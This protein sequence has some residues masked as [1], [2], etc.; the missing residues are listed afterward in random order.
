MDS[1]KFCGL[2]NPISAQYRQKSGIYFLE[3]PLIKYN[4]ERCFKF[5]MAEASSKDLSGRLANY[6]TAYGPANFIIHLLWEI[7]KIVEGISRLYCNVEQHIHAI[8]IQEQFLKK[9]NG[10]LI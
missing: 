4:G 10:L 8:L 3:Q 7:P 2:E 5:G 6:K 9:K 1:H